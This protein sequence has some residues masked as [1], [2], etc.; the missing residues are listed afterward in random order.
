MTDTIS[1]EI[2]DALQAR[3]LA[4]P[5]NADKVSLFRAVELRIEN[6]TLK[7]ES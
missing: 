2:Y 5:D 7:V 1:Q 3:A 6:G 4:D